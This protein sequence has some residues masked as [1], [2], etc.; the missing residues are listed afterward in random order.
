MPQYLTHK[1][2]TYYF[3]Q[4]VPAELRAI[5]GRREL[6]WS[7]GRDYVRALHE[8]KVRAVEAGNI[9]ANARAELDSCLVDPFSR[10]GIRRTKHAVLKQ[11]TPQLE[12]EFEGL[13]R[14]ALLESDEQQRVDGHDE[15]SF[16]ELSE[17]LEAAIP[18]LRKQLAMGKVE[19]MMESSRWMLVGRGL[20]LDRNFVPF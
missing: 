2:N 5:V 12:L 8:C 18:V 15:E 11:L 14:A 20:R 7:L 17:H 16:D 10:A 6:K 19:P 9:L 1:A 3:R 4:G 13:V